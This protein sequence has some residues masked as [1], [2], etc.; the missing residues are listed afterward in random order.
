[1]DAHIYQKDHKKPLEVEDLKQIQYFSVV[2]DGLQT[3]T[4]NFSDFS[5]NNV[6]SEVKFVGKSETVLIRADKIESI[7]FDESFI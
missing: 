7:K 3:L 4:D 1:M 2:G 5:L 6:V